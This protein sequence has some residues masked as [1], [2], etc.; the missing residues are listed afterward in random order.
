MAIVARLMVCLVGTIAILMALTVESV[1]DL[2]NLCSDVVYVLLFPQF[3]CFFHLQQY[4]NTYGVLLGM[5]A[6]LIF[7][8]LF[9]TP[10]DSSSLG[11]LECG[12]YGPQCATSG[13]LSLVG[14]NWPLLGKIIS[15][16]SNKTAPPCLA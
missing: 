5:R 16:I 14:H 7:C 6:P 13:S 15:F 10:C 3:L 11:L 2:W 12:F 1:Y 9:L 8:N 4:T